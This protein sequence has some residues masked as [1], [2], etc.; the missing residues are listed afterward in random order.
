MIGYRHE[1]QIAP[2]METER[3]ST[4]KRL[5]DFADRLEAGEFVAVVVGVCSSDGVGQFHVQFDDLNFICPC[6]Q[7]RG[8]FDFPEFIN[9]LAQS[10]LSSFN[11]RL[12][13][14]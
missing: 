7:E 12:N 6:C 2:N 10:V 4:A 11:E 8:N 14:G 5:R 13:G 3:R 1:N 9:D